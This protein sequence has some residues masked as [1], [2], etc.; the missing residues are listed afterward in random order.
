MGYA[1]CA[2]LAY[3]LWWQ[4]PSITSEPTLVRITH[5]STI[6]ARFRDTQNAVVPETH[7]RQKSDSP[8]NTRLGNRDEEQAVDDNDSSYTMTEPIGGNRKVNSNDVIRVSCWGQTYQ[9]ACWAIISIAHGLFYF[10]AWN[11]G[12]PTLPECI[13]W[14]ICTVL[15]LLLGSAA[16]TIIHIITEEGQKSLFTVGIPKRPLFRFYM[17]ILL[18]YALVRLFM[19]V[20]ALR[21]FFYLP[22]STFQDASWSNYLPNFS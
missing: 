17:A 19:I 6:F 5:T 12:F 7:I 21:G 15:S 1:F 16:V 14:R 2:V 11:I 10:F 8:Q 4:K 3:A 18:L 22:L 13:L 9:T 20:E